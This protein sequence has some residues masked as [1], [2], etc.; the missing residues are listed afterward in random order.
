MKTDD[1]K[2]LIPVPGTIL[3]RTNQVLK[4]GGKLEGNFEKIK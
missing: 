1:L 3:K 2:K 4:I